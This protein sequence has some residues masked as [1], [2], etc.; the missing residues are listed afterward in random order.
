M[1]EEVAD[2]LERSNL[3]EP[4]AEAIA[5][6]YL[7][8]AEWQHPLTDEQWADHWQRWGIDRRE[9]FRRQAE[10]AILATGLLGRLEELEGR[11]EEARRE[12][13]TLPARTAAETVR[14]IGRARRIL[15]APSRREQP[16]Q[17]RD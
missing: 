6:Q 3:I 14:G 7:G 4:V 8:I 10:A 13:E 2:A 12:L 11:I 1:S 5:R 17:I 9:R 16:L 15:A